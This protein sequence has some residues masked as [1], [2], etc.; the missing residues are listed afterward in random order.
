M[1]RI[2]YLALVAGLTLLSIRSFADVTGLWPL[3]GAEPAGDITRAANTELQSRPLDAQAF[4]ALGLAAEREGDGK[5]ADALFTHSIELDPRLPAPR[6]SLLT[7]AAGTKDAATAVRH[8]RVLAALSPEAVAPIATVLADLARDPAARRVIGREAKDTPLIL[9]VAARASASGMATPALRELLAPTNLTSLPNGVTAAQ[10]LIVRP[11]VRDG[12]F[13]EARLA[14][15]A[16][17]G[18]TPEEA[19]FDG[20]FR[21]LTGS[22]PF[23]WTLR[24]GTDIETSIE[25]EPGASPPTALKVTAFGSLQVAAAEQTLVLPAGRHRLTFEASSD[26][27][28]GSAPA[29]A[30]HLIC[31]NGPLVTEVPL[32]FVRSGWQNFQATLVVPAGC[33]AQI[34]RLIKL[35]TPDSRARSLEVTNVAVRPL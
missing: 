18:L 26:T 3:T 32:A 14:W 1:L 33:P 20:A 22:P 21:G 29:F 10:A 23:G 8:A 6:L 19:A 2:G 24:N 28:H 30:W 31:S 9:A 16:L 5:R 25:H 35:R 12:K 34:L 4:Y 11:L 17:A 7:R 27:P 15:Y 13:R